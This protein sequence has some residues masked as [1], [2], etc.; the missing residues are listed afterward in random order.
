[1]NLYTKDKPFD[2]YDIKGVKLR[3]DVNSLEGLPAG[4]YIID[5]KKIA[6]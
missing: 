2:I 3:N 1:M 5:G 6:K 4:T